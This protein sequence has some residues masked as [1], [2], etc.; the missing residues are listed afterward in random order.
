MKKRRIF[1]EESD[2]EIAEV[3]DEE[4]IQ[5]EENCEEEDDENEGEAE[6][7]DEQEEKM[8]VDSEPVEEVCSRCSTGGT[9][10]CCDNCPMMYH[11]ECSE[12]PLRR[13]PRGKWFCSD[14]KN[15]QSKENNSGML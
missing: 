15:K 14:C 6:T 2:E 12:P 5:E 3:E 9:L 7:N 1:K 8:D 11:L 4:E 13:V 10:L